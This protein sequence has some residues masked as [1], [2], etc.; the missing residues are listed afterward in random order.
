MKLIFSTE[1]VVKRHTIS[2]FGKLEKR[3]L[4]IKSF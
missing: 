2:N 3:Y 4:Q 1:E